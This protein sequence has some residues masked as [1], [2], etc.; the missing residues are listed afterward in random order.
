MNLND[1]FYN[2][3]CFSG[4]CNHIVFDDMITDGNCLT[5]A[6]RIEVLMLHPENYDD[7]GEYLISIG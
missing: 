4:F 5:V 2:K 6:Q 3:N 1:E 7:E